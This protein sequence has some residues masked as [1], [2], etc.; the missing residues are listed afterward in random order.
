M[1][2]TV[3]E[4]GPNLAKLLSLVFVCALLAFVTWAFVKDGKP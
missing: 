3:I 4:I 1:K 2:V